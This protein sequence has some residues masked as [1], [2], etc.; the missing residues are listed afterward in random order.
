MFDPSKL[1][2]DPN[3]DQ[4]E[5]K[6]QTPE[7]KE[8]PKKP[9][10]SHTSDPLS[11]EIKD[12]EASD[13]ETL[14][15]IEKVS[16]GEKA[17][18]IPPTPFI[19]G[20]ETQ[21]EEKK[22]LF[23]IN[24]TKLSDILDEIIAKGSDFV[25]I[26]P[27]EDLV[28]VSF[29]KDKVETEK[30]YIKYPVY[31]Q[32]VIQTKNASGL[33]I[34]VSTEQQEGNKE[35]N[36]KGGNYQIICRCVPSPLG[37]KVFIKLKKIQKKANKQ[38][39]SSVSPT[40][41]LTFL[42]AIAFVAVVLGGGFISF[43]ALNAK[44]VQDVAFFASLGV[45]LGEINRFIQS[46]VTVT[47]SIL[48]FIETIFLVVYLFKFALTKKIFKQKKIRQG[49]IASFFFILTFVTGSTWIYID[50]VVDNLP[51]WENKSRGEIQ[52]YYN[53]RLKSEAFDVNGALI[54]TSL[55]QSLIGPVE[56]KYDLKVLV[57]NEAEKGFQVQKYIWDFGDRRPIETTDSSIIYTFEEKGT[58]EPKLTLS[59]IDFNGENIEKEVENIPPV[60]ISYLVGVNERKLN[61]SGTLVEF[62]ANELKELG[63]VEWYFIE[64]LDT[65]AFTGYQFKTP[66]K[67]DEQVIA[68]HIVRND[69]PSGTVDKL[70]IIPGESENTIGGDI[71]ATRSLENDL[72]FE[73]KV[74]DISNTFGNGFIEEF[75]WIIGD[76]EIT[77]FGDI[78]NPSESS[79]ITHIF[80]EYGDQEVRVVLTNSSGEQKEIVQIIE[81]PKTLGLRN[82]LIIKEDGEEVPNI[83]YEPATREYYIRD[84]GSP[85]EISLE[86]K[87][88]K[89][90]NIKY[91]LHEVKWDTNNDGD[92]DSKSKNIDLE[93][94]TEQ[95]Y[96]VSVEYV[97][98][99]RVVPD[100][101]ISVK[102]TIFLE[103]IDKEVI[104][105]VGVTQE[106]EYA[107]TTVRFDASR[108]RVKDG[109]IAK[110][111]WDYGDGI[112]QEADAIIPAHKYPFPGEYDIVVT[113]V[114]DTGERHS[115]NKKVILKPRP[116]RAEITTSLKST[117]TYQA[118]DFSSKKSQ[119]QISA[120]YWDFGDGVNSTEANPSHF[121]KKPGTYKVK[122][123]L[124]FVNNNTLSDTVE[125]EVREG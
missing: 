74:D 85:T 107:P 28:E 119:G 66:K 13:Q 33:D 6:K 115:V 22:I 50:R 16:S 9:E 117:V 61:R 104:V 65:P 122:L 58:Y 73:L 118:I 88:I 56:I 97:F 36:L 7:P 114:S 81:I 35:I 90:S 112:I 116:E 87:H 57:E 2:L 26:E 60:N 110:F 31:S 95:D 38:Q 64:N 44:T 25:T 53:N 75:K 40:Q 17:E 102:E 93:L 63:K 70:F 24:L 29:K 68:I 72:E 108:S 125:I 3:N 4:N 111:I 89:P 37:E 103:A 82:S 21:K 48:V 96:V 11:V 123:T 12:V 45:D 105:H 32:I 15:V 39:K 78:E 42:G 55:S 1:D 84:L 83:I 52:M 77:A 8:S 92:I 14:A 30:K 41:I 91:T 62:D 86:A 19:K 54:D 67:Q 101:L 76:R 47:F 27:K 120:Y 43:V 94:P 59:G 79:K 121:Y 46:T 69:K 18:K 71:I 80:S 5:A 10:T 98:K 100:E 113:V 106:S 109:N 20:G 34:S 49:V 99:N 124:D 23:D 51:D